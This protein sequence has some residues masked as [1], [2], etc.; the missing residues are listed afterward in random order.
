MKLWIL[1]IVCMI[2]SALVA[3]FLALRLKKFAPDLYRSVDSP[4][5]FDRNP[6]FWLYHFFSPSKWTKLSKGQRTAAALGLT[7]LSSSLALITILLVS[8]LRHGSL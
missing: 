8:F 6:P 4:V 7:L 3:S 2:A 5:A 1:A